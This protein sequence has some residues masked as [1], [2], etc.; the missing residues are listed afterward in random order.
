M[1]I[2]V[3]L[4]L[5]KETPGAVRYAEVNDKGDVVKGEDSKI[6]T[7]YIRKSALGGETPGRLAVRIE[8]L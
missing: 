5:E 7:L 3:K 1:I 4:V 8:T 2:E 6:T